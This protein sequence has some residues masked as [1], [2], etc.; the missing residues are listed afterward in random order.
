MSEVWRPVVG[1]E[2]AYEVSNLGRVRSLDRL[3][4]AG[5][6]RERR[7]QGRVL[8]AYFG[9]HYAKVRLKVGDGGR[10]L[11]VH[12]LVAEAFLGPRPDGLE[13]CHNNGERHDNR[14]ENLRYDTHVENQRDTIRLGRNGWA[15]RTHC[16]N[17]HE[18]T[19]ENTRIRINYGKAC[20]RTCRTCERACRG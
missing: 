2:G 10:T 15:N 19:P 4:P 9:D 12:Q 18:F 3:V 11:N 6:G 17:G 8:S 13:V 1:Y 20:G 5:G 14:A 16:K 7:H